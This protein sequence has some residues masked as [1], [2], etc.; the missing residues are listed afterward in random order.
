MLRGSLWLRE[1]NKGMGWG[2]LPASFSML[3]KKWVCFGIKIAYISKEKTTHLGLQLRR[4]LT[5][6][7]D[8]SG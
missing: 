6:W 1:T 4:T 2:V 3:K 8:F 7:K 5:W